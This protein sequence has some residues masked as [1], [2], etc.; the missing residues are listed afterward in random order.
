MNFDEY[1]L[2]AWG[3]AQ[4]PQSGNNI[5]Y[6]ALGLAGEAGEAVDKIKKIWR[7]QGI[8]NGQLYTQEQKYAL[9]QEV[10]DVLWYISAICAEL[11]IKLSL[12]ADMNIAKLKD[13]TERNVIKGEGDN[14]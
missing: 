8:S 1:Q 12:V 5:I 6:P 7:N 9:L 2:E 14:R 4:Y 11:G 10:G 13:R 3:L